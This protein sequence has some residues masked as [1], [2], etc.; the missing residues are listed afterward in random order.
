MINSILSTV[1]VFLVATVV[2]GLMACG[3]SEGTERVDP[4]YLS[5]LQEMERE[6]C[7]CAKDVPRNEV[8]ACMAARKAR[9]PSIPGG[10]DVEKYRASLRPE[11]RKAIEEIEIR[12]RA[13]LDMIASV[14]P[15]E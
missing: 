5:A 12:R 4:A 15:A 8:E 13:C 11:D 7:H 6:A 2:T 3:K 14:S 1:R 9:N 10:Q